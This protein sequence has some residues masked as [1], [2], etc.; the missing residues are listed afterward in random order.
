MYSG[1]EEIHR[2]LEAKLEHLHLVVALVQLA[3][4]LPVAQVGRVLRVSA[5][6]P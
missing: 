1:R 6:E 3:F 5:S 4:L 2:R